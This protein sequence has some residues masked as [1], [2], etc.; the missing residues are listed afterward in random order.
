LMRLVCVAF[1]IVGSLAQLSVKNLKDTETDS[2]TKIE[3]DTPALDALPTSNVTLPTHEKTPEELTAEDPDAIFVGRDYLSLTFPTITSKV[4]NSHKGRGQIKGQPELCSYLLTASIGLQQTDDLHNSRLYDLAARLECEWTTCRMCQ[5]RMAH[6][7]H[8]CTIHGNKDWLLRGVCEDFNPLVEAARLRQ[9]IFLDNAPSCRVWRDM[10]VNQ[11][12]CGPD[13][14]AI[15]QG[16][17]TIAEVCHYLGMNEKGFLQ[18]QP[19]SSLAPWFCQKT[20]QCTANILLE[21]AGVDEFPSDFGSEPGALG[22]G[23][24]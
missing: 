16:A 10:Q 5:Q 13:D 8:Y 19:L 1:F 6:V 14:A 20:M 2:L 21:V 15:C 11:V 12:R 7:F 23:L 22:V 17:F 4:P 24:E 9:M 18:G 3:S